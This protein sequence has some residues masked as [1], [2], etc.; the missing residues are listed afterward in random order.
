MQPRLIGRLF[1]GLRYAGRRSSV[2]RAKGKFR[3][4]ESAGA[5]AMISTRCSAECVGNQPGEDGPR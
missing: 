3:L 1:R 5:A 4:W 2:P